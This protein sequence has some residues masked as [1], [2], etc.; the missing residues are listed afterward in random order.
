MRRVVK[1]ILPIDDDNTPY[2]AQKLVE[3]V[4]KTKSEKVEF[5]ERD[6]MRGKF[7]LP[8]NLCKCTV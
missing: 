2:R 8:F 3:K 4:L 6:A 5:N 7:C 1:N